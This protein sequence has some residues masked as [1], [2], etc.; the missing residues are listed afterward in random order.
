MPS[1]WTT[2]ILVYSSTAR[3]DATYHS[4]YYDSMWLHD[5]GSIKGANS[6]PASLLMSRV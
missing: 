6:P 4:G 5:S 2:M 3:G 1:A